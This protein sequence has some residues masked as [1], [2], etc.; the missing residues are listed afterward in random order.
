M[1]PAKKRSVRRNNVWSDFTEL[2]LIMKIKKRNH[3]ILWWGEGFSVGSH[4][5][6]HDAI[7]EE[8][9]EGNSLTVS[10]FVIKSGAGRA[11][12]E[13]V[14]QKLANDIFIIDLA[15]ACIHEA[16]LRI[17]AR[18]KF[19]RKVLKLF[20]LALVLKMPKLRSHDN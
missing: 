6:I 11:V 7:S 14:F 8:H 17:D 4:F 16:I 10:S 3:F 2:G 13:L 5:S 15:S 9:S 19:L 12:D 18:Q 1:S 20:T